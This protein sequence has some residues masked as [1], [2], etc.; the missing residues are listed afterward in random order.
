MSFLEKEIIL[1]DFKWIRRV[2][3]NLLFFDTFFDKIIRF[4]EQGLKVF[5]LYFIIE[6][7]VI[8]PFLRVDF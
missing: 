6:K 8:E 3:R 5:L 2:E 7:L 4:F 1:I